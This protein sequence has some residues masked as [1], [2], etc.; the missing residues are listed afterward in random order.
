MSLE[1]REAGPDD[2]Q[3]LLELYRRVAAGGELARRPEE[4]DAHYVDGFLA[5]ATA[6]GL[7]LI[8]E[9]EAGLVGELHAYAPE[10][11]SFRHVW[12]SLTIV[13]DPTTQGQGVGRALFERFLHT[14]Q[15]RPDVRRVE[16][17]VRESNA[18]ARAFYE[19]L[20]FVAEGRFEGRIRRADGGLEA[21]IPMAWIRPSQDG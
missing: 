20:G 2:R 18:R 13:V 9:S 4:I 5:A 15:Q 1:L 21:D 3:A 12:S 19:S 10:P 11:A 17:F 7:A 16:L 8:A 6:R 14:I